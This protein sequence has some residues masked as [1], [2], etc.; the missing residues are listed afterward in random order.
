M[1]KLLTG[2]ESKWFR[3]PGK[4]ETLGTTKWGKWRP[5]WYACRLGRKQKELK[6]HIQMK[7]CDIIGAEITDVVSQ[8]AWLEC[9]DELIQ[10]LQEGRKGRQGIN[11]GEVALYA[12]ELEV[13]R[14]CIQ[15]TAGWLKRCGN[16]EI[17]G[18]ASEHCGGKFCQATWSGSGRRQIL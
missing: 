10:D 8:P 17:R 1:W 11:Q 12:K 9:C 14:S 13:Y 2:V 6:L 18:V 5:F 7:S 4:T 3:V 16:L 15:Q